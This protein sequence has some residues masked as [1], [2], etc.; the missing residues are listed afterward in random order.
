MNEP[1]SSEY[2]TY[3]TVKATFWPWLSDLV[4]E[5]VGL[6]GSR[7]QLPV[8]LLQHREL[9]RRERDQTGVTCEKDASWQC[10]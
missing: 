5:V 9:L 1:L 6:L 4:L 2:G 3:K 8:L 10:L 7:A